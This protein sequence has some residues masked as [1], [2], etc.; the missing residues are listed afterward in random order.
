MDKT[1]QIRS[2]LRS[3]AGTDKP[4]FGF[5]L[6]EV[7]GVEGD[8]CR[9]K[10]EDSKVT[11]NNGDN[12]GLVKIEA[13]ERSLESLKSYCEQLKQAVSSGLN[14]VGAGTAA[15]GATGATAFET[16]MSA[17]AIRIEDLE[18]SKITH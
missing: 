5:R 16:A 3:I 11:F 2:L 7:V 15:N 1:T 9:A 14:S 4:S 10:I 12:G 13:L 18:N 6:M 8:L 17:A